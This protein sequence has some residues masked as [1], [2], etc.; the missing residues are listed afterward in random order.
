MTKQYFYGI[1]GIHFIWNG[2][3]ADSHLRY[4]GKTVNYYNVENTLWERYKEEFPNDKWE[5]LMTDDARWKRWVKSH[6]SEVKEI[7]AHCSPV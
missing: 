7:I 2:N 3:A 4:K 1:Y 5:D 6:S